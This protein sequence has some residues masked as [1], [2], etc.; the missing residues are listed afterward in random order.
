MSKAAVRIG[1]IGAGSNTRRRHIPGL[2]NQPGVELVGVVNRSPESSAR[3]AQSLGIPKTYSDWR[4]LIDD[5]QINAVLIGTWPYLHCEATCA[6]LAA[7]KHVLCE[8]RMSRDL[9]EARRMLEASQTHPQLVAQLVPS[10]YGLVCGAAIQQIVEEGFLGQL[11]EVVVLGADDQFWDYSLPLHWRQQQ[12][13]SG[14]NILSLGILHETVLRWTPAPVQVFA[15]TQ[16][17]E[18]ERPVPDECRVAAVDVPDSLQVLTQIA[19]GARGIYHQSGS[20]LFGPGKQIH[21]YGS[22]GTIKVEF[23]PDGTERVWL[24]YAGEDAMRQFEIPADICG[25]WRVEEEFVA[26]IR[27]EEK[28]ALTDFATGVRYMEFIDA[29]FESAAGNRPV[30][31]SAG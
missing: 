25:R 5:P 24:G 31:L 21:L 9:A 20:I 10:P 12:S 15:Q 23:R 29:V 30:K 14:K 4:Q 6:A 8:A 16:L 17:F 13:L 1:I 28:V 19:G 18:A 22:R 2:R 26:A 3:A 27:G 11:R 7:G